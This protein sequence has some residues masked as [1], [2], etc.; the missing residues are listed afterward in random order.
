M[1]QNV[2]R[3]KR[4]RNE[5][6]RLVSFTI[7]KEGTK[8]MITIG[9]KLKIARIENELSQAEVAERLCISRQT[10]SKWELD[11]SAPDLESLRQLAIIYNLSVD[12][13][14]ELAEE[15]MKMLNSY[16]EEKLTE[17][18]LAKICKNSPSIEQFQFLLNEIVSP[19][20]AEWQDVSW[21]SV[22]KQLIIPGRNNSLNHAITSLIG[23]KCLDLFPSYSYQ[24]IFLTKTTLGVVSLID[25]LEKREVRT[26]SMEEMA[27]FAVG[28]MY[29]GTHRLGNQSAVFYK[30]KDGNYD[31]IG[32][33]AHEAQNL[34]KVLTILDPCNTYY[35]PLKDVSV[36]AFMKKYRNKSYR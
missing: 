25:W 36:M 29:T 34:T 8:M 19:L 30:T 18:V 28:N 24:I 10:L 9:G 2:A 26:Y 27:L 15:K 6:M 21:F 31:M 16:S 17:G 35:V 23:K 11:K 14:L 22:Q 3:L 4:G 7:R 33:T 12:S 13:L 1:Q 5:L 20:M 32:L